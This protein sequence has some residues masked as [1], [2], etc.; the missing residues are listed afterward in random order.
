MDRGALRYSSRS[1]GIRL[2]AATPAH[3]HDLQ[4]SPRFAVAAGSGTDSDECEFFAPH[5]KRVPRKAVDAARP[6]GRLLPP[7]CCPLP[8]GTAQG[9]LGCDRGKQVLVLIAL[10]KWMFY[11]PH[12]SSQIPSSSPYSKT[13]R[14]TCFAFLF[15][16][17]TATIPPNIGAPHLTAPMGLGFPS[18]PP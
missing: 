13:H 12:W 3:T 11:L 9:G 14:G 1:R 8:A 16:T 7:S 2:S 18:I 10:R 5:S 15:F 6:S 17:L 4:R